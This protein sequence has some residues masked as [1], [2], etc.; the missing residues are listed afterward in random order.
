VGVG[1][2]VGVAGTGVSVGVWVQR[3]FMGFKTEH[4][5]HME[6]LLQALGMEQV[7]VFYSK[8]IGD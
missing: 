2:D 6:K 7:E 3:W 4:K 5:K 1:V 8:W